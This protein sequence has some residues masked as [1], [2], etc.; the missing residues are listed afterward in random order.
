MNTKFNLLLACGAAALLSG[1]AL[2][3]PAVPTT[4]LTGKIGG[5]AFEIRNPKQTTISNLSVEIATNGAAK[6]TIGGLSSV[7]DSNV[8]GAGYSGQADFVNAVGAQLNQAVQNGAALA[9]KAAVK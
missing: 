9:A 6:L 1:C 4:V 8:V 3:Q 2:L 5:Q 7:N